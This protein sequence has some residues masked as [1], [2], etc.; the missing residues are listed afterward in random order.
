MEEEGQLYGW[1][2]I[3][4]RTP[5]GWCAYKPDLPTILGAAD[6]REE[7]EQQMRAAALY[8]ESLVIFRE[9]GNRIGIARSLRNLGL[10]A[11]HQGDL[12]SAA[13]LHEEALALRRELGD[14]Y[15]VAQSLSNLGLVAYA[16]GNLAR[17]A[18][19]LGEGMALTRELDFKQLT[20]VVLANLGTVALARGDW[21]QAA[22]AHTEGLILARDHCVRLLVAAGLEGLARVAL[23]PGNPAGDPHRAAQ[24]L[25]AAATARITLGMPLPPDE[26]AG[27]EA[28]RAATL[29][30]LGEETFAAAWAEGQALRMEDAVALALETKP[31][32]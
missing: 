25:A 16:Q 7:V 12:A 30:A 23:T 28:A 24:L 9:L 4:E 32:V 15:G 13:A 3:Y 19:L 21:L 2:V 29:A 18:T 1:L 10:V 17:A 26:Q 20:A 14:R 5:T 22:A 8:E 11:H 27:V 6:T 31:D